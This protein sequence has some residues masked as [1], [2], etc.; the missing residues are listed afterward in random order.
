MRN[1]T[2][3]HR[4][5]RVPNEIAMISTGIRRTYHAAVQHAGH[6][7]VVHVGQIAAHL[8]GNVHARHR[9]AD[10]GVIGGRF[11]GRFVVEVQDL[12]AAFD[13]CAISQAVLRVGNGTHHTALQL[14]SVDCHAQLLRRLCQQPLAR[15]RCCSAQRPGMNLDGCA[16]N[17]GALV[18]RACGVAQH[19]VHLSQR[20]IEL[21]GH[22]LRQR[23]ADAS[24]QVHMAIECGGAAVVPHGQ[25]NFHP[26]GRVTRHQRGL[27]L[28]GWRGGRGVAHHQQHALRGV[29][30]IARERR[31]RAQCRRAG[32]RGQERVGWGG[33]GWASRISTAARWTARMICTCVPQRH[34]L[35]ESS[36]RIAV[37][38]GSGLRSSRA[39]AIITMP[40][41]Q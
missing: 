31:V 9:G 35:P 36:R 1:G 24:A 28:D 17:G 12:M 13:E 37:S 25:Q 14:Q 20:H 3:V 38:S 26:L 19:H 30:I 4:L 8:A 40:F 23:G 33:H 5:Q 11:G 27:S 41:R 10:H 29:K 2:L 22:D 7:H 34:R 21:F 15:L 39:T 16:G 6:A 18:G 32:R